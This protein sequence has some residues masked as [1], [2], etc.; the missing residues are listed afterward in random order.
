MGN[1]LR[2]GR[3]KKKI[4]EAEAKTAKFEAA[5]AGRNCGARRMETLPSFRRYIA[6]QK[7]WPPDSGVEN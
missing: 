5:A 7:N 3:V 1:F 6:S 2:G 4:P